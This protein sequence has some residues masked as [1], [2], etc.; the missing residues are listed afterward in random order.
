MG[1]EKLAAVG[2][3]ARIGHGEHPG[4][5]V[6]KPGAEF[7]PEFVPGITGPCSARASALNHKIRD[8]PVE[9]QPIVVWLSG[10]LHTI[11]EAPFGQADKIAH[12][13]RRFPMGKFNEDFP[14]ARVE[15]CVD[16]FLHNRMILSGKYTLFHPAAMGSFT[17]SRRPGFP[18]REHAGQ[19]GRQGKPSWQPPVPAPGD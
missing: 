12:G 5:I 13:P 8:H 4:A 1:N 15:F 18:T 3:R 6:F 14:F 2:P 10:F 16:A 11:S 19:K 7:V 17:A 9:S